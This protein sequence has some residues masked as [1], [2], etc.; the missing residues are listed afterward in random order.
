VTYKQ[1][2]SIRIDPIGQVVGGRAELTDDSWDAVEA[3]IA[4]DPSQFGT[5]A[6][7]GLSDFSHIEVIFAFDR[8]ADDEI[9]MGARH[10]RGRADWPMVGI[11]A[12]RGKVRPNRIGVSVCKLLSVNGLNLSVRG[13]DAADGSPVLDIKPVMSGFLPRG[14]LREPQWAKEIMRN[15]W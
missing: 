12:Q 2:P 9:E 3:R 8:V 10:P 1:E 7:L 4:L 5:E 15:Y 14:E 13:L 11:F 6:T